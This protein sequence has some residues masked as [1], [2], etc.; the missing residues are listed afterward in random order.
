MYRPISLGV[1]V[2][3]VV[4]C[5]PAFADTLIGK[6]IKVADGDTI[7]IL[8]HTNTQHR[9]RLQG[10]DA[11]E[12]SQPFGNASR[13]HLASLVA[14]KSVTVEWGKRDRYGRIVGFVIVDGQDVNLEQLKAGMAWFY[15]YYQNELTPEDRKRYAQAED[16]AR[17][18]RLGLW[19]DRNPIPPWEWRRQK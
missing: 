9:I 12:K 17:A 4:F 10:I 6:V 8:D 16:K 14:G 11:P 2:V 18:D 1:L 13:K 7:T 3:L 15:H 5:R 19:Q